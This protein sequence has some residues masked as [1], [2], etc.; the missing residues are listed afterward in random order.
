MA[1]LA[2]GSAL[3]GSLIWENEFTDEQS[4]AGASITSQDVQVDISTSVVSDNDSG[5]SDIST[6]G[7]EANFFS[8]EAGTQ[9]AHAG[10]GFLGFNNIGNDPADYLEITFTF[11]SAIQ[12]VTFSLLD[13]DQR[14]QGGASDFDDGVIVTYNGTVDTGGINIASFP[15]LYTLHP[16]N[17]LADEP[18]TGFE[19]EPAAGTNDGTLSTSPDANIDFDLASTAVTSLTIRYFST[20]DAPANPSGQ[21]LGISDMS[22]SFVPE[23]GTAWLVALALLATAAGR[24]T[25]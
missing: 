1:L 13:I 10:Y 17:A 20:D 2:P 16:N 14:A 4:I 18:W 8:F 15:A 22:W 25:R 6:F 5:G 3:A 23:P 11:A 24:R 7:S 19:G 9:G 21:L 12:D